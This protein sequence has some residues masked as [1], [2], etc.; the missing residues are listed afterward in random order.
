KEFIANQAQQI[1]E[2]IKAKKFK[3][4]SDSF[5]DSYLH[6]EDNLEFERKT[7]RVLR[8]LGLNT[9]MHP[10]PT[11]AFN[12]SNENIDVMADAFGEKLILV[13][14]KNYAKNFNLSAALRNVMANSYLAGY[15]GFN[16]LNPSYYCYVTANTSSNEANLLKINEL[17][18]KNSNLDVHGMMISASALYWLLNYCSGNEIDEKERVTMFL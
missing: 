11:T 12:N 14:A 7:A 2:D 16:G 10:N 3:A 15:K 8:G 1:A 17:A 4:A 18:K 13:D 6:E 9:E 5:I